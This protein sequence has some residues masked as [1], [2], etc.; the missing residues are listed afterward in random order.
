MYFYIVWKTLENGI[1]ISENE[2]K[3]K[4]EKKAW[5]RIKGYVTLL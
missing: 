3:P 4:E 5:D 1:V 2:T